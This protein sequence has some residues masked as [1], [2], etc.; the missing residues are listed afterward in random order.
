MAAALIYTNTST[1]NILKAG[2]KA[3]QKTPSKEYID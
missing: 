1:I 3:K 2:E